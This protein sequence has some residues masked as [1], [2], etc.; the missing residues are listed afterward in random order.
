MSTSVQDGYNILLA[1]RY[2]DHSSS[3][4]E[5]KPYNYPRT[6]TFSHARNH[7]HRSLEPMAYNYVKQHLIFKQHMSVYIW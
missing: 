6:L 5:A 3:W 1:T 7:G 2:I 4:L